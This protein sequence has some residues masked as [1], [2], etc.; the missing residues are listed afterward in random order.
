LC[1]TL[2]NII[3]YIIT[4]L[5][6]QEASSVSLEIL[7]TYD[8]VKSNLNVFSTTLAVTNDGLHVVNVEN[9]SNVTI[10]IN[11]LTVFYKGV[12]QETGIWKWESKII[13]SRTIDDPYH[14]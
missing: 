6:S 2:L 10:G 1:Q 12:A 9:T 13:E 11:L 5:L 7:K 4:Y 8:V 14:T 3:L